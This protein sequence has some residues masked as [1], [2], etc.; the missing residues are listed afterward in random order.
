LIFT[1][2]FRVVCNVIHKKAEVMASIAVTQ[3]ASEAEESGCGSFGSD[4]I[5]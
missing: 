4:N 2:I 5:N 1:T 3:F